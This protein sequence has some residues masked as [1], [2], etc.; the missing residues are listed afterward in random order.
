MGNIVMGNGHGPS[1]PPE[2]WARSGAAQAR[3]VRND[4]VRN[5]GRPLAVRAQSR[6]DVVS[7]SY[8]IISG[9]YKSTIRATDHYC[10]VF[11]NDG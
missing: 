1:G 4:N 11:L 9:L 8:V 2:D 5:H 6:T 10:C 7:L 3:N